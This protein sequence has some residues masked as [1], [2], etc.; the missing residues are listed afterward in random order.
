MTG[1]GIRQEE[2]I[3]TDRMCTEDHEDREEITLDGLPVDVPD[4]EGTS[5]AFGR[6]KCSFLKWKL[7][8]R[9]RFSCRAFPPLRVLR[10]LLCGSYSFFAAHSETLRNIPVSLTPSASGPELYNIISQSSGPADGKLHLGLSPRPL[11]GIN[12]PSIRLIVTSFLTGST[13][14]CKAP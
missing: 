11:R 13:S 14:L 4:C 6:L 1:L 12:R 8:L 9:P 3:G 2:P 5:E 7:T 10:V